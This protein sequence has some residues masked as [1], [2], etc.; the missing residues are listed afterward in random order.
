MKNIVS[1]DIK[2]GRQAY[3]SQQPPLI[4]MQQ[5]KKADLYSSCGGG[6]ERSILKCNL[7]VN[8]APHMTTR[9]SVSWN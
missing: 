4:Y 5:K 7:T 8:Q 3:I 9:D 1:F 6:K 2:G